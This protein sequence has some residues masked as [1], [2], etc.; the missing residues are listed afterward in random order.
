[1]VV[2]SLFMFECAIML[3]FEGIRVLIWRYW[4]DQVWIWKLL[5][6][7]KVILLTFLVAAGMMNSVPMPGLGLQMRPPAPPPSG[8]PP[9]LAGP[10]PLPPG[11]P[12]DVALGP[13]V[14]EEVLKSLP[15]AVS[16]FLSRL[17]AVNGKSHKRS[18]VKFTWNCRR[19]MCALCLPL[20]CNLSNDSSALLILT[21]SCESPMCVQVQYQM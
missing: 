13:K 17:P 10:P 9:R 12:P 8:L 1:M 7:V 14:S 20:T 11:R 15:S 21:A 4:M 3:V 2:F 5:N 16:S 18:I 6:V 19:L